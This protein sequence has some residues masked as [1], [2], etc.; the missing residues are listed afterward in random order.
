M[1][2]TPDQLAELREHY[3]TTSTAD[4]MTDAGGWETDI[5]PDPMVTTSLRLPK[6]LLDWVRAQA[7][8]EKVKPTALVRRWVE[9]RRDHAVGPAPAGDDLVERLER[10]ERAV[11]EQVR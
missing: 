5:D 8:A 9:E 1:S 4:E 7:M 10:L 2:M 11:F 3:D 6:S